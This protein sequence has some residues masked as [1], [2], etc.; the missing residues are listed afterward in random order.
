MHAR[1]LIKSYLLELLLKGGKLRYTAKNATEHGYRFSHSARFIPQSRMRL[2]LG[3]P[4]LI[5]VYS[6]AL[7]SI[8]A[9]IGARLGGTLHIRHF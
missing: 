4:I 5:D 6:L 1:S 3:K 2:Q 7:I 8:R 9:V